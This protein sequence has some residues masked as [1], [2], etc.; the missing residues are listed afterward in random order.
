MFA[1]ASLTNL[2]ISVPAAKS[3]KIIEDSPPLMQSA[4]TS[5][6]ERATETLDFILLCMEMKTGKYNMP[7]PCIVKDLRPP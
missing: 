2:A 7:A 4:Y 3:E 5:P 6:L 1:G